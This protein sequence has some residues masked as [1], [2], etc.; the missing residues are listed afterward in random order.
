LIYEYRYPK[1]A[2]KANFSARQAHR[3]FPAT[4]WARPSGRGKGTAYEPQHETNSVC[5]RLVC[6]T[7]AGLAMDYGDIGSTTAGFI[8]ARDESPTA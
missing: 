7:A 4:V 1:L 2:S 6:I 5:Q 3:L 8:L